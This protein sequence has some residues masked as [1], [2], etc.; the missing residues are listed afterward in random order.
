MV[1]QNI[2]RTLCRVLSFV[3][4]C[5]RHKRKFI[6]LFSQWS[7]T[8]IDRSKKNYTMNN[9]FSSFARRKRRLKSRL[10][11]AA[12]SSPCLFQCGNELKQDISRREMYSFRRD[13][14]VNEFIEAC[15][16]I[17]RMDF[18][19]EALKQQNRKTP[20]CLQRDSLEKNQWTGQ[21][22]K[23][24]EE[25]ATGNEHGNDN[26]VEWRQSARQRL[27]KRDSTRTPHF[28]DEIML[29]EN[30]DNMVEKE[31]PEIA[32]ESRAITRMITYTM[33]D[34]IPPGDLK[35]NNFKDSSLRIKCMS[36]DTSSKEEEDSAI[37][38]PA[39]VESSAKPHPKL[40]PMK[41]TKTTEDDE[42][43]RKFKVFVVDIFFSSSTY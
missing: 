20:Q 7:N 43:A 9:Y 36:E 28:N 17:V 21:P 15:R 16:G 3:T 5:K 38:K 40:D 26:V 25:L 33:N 31:I 23:W 39:P 30:I 34:E 11:V 12:E 27:K 1:R 22:E 37:K 29:S 42:K 8:V 35:Q 13:R 18:Q 4:S 19:S 24:T 41:W 14:H 6:P 10:H 2:L 32:D